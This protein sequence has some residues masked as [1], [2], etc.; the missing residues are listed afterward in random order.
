[1]EVG[2][3]AR[4]EGVWGEDVT[5]LGGGGKGEMRERSLRSQRIVDACNPWALAHDSI[6]GARVKSFGCGCNPWA[7]A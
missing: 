7:L 5:E 6:F 1:V 4:G 3:G 2:T